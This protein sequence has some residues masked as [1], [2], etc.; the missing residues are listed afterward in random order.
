[1]LGADDQQY[2]IS[3]LISFSDG[4]FGFAITL[5]V[6][7][8]PFSLNLPPSASADQIGQQLLSI[9][10]NFYAY[11]FSFYMVGVYWVAH[12]RMF[13]YII[14]SDT[15]LLWVNL[16]LLLFIVFLPFPTS[17]VARYG[18]TSIITALYA[19]TL[20]MIGLIYVIM[21]EY[22]SSHHR[23][24]PH[25]LDPQTRRYIRWR[26]LLP[27]GIFAISIGISFLSPSLA[28]V[29]W[30]AIF[31]VRPIFLRKYVGKGS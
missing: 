17:L 15:G 2:G 7:T 30:F 25:D 1:M 14:K 9:L 3:R 28:K 6:T 21:W 13:G 29:A 10:P 8:I 22:A 4:V 5:L 31:L 11:L 16:T 19:A 26:G 27:L 18:A 20:S 12:H 23:L 24:I